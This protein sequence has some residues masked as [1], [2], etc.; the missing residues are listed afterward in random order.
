MWSHFQSLLRQ[1]DI[2]QSRTS[3]INPLQWTLTIAVVGLLA[4]SLE[5]HAP[6]WLAIFFAAIVGAV[7]VL[8]LFAFVFF[9]IKGPDALR[10]EKYS[11]VKT[12]IEKRLV[13]DSLTGLLQVVETF[14]GTD[15]KALSTGS[16]IEPKS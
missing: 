11:L 7:I 3:V 6:P 14:E 5:P 9:M 1:A 15:P 8:L 16:N 12:A 10:S 13:G 2:G 4:V